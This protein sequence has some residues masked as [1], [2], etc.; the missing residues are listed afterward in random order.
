MMEKVVVRLLVENH[1]MSDLQDKRCLACEGGVKSLSTA[2]KNKLLK[3]INQRW[4]VNE[5]Y[6]ELSSDFK[7]KNY[8]QTMAFINA[9]A[10]MAHQEN[11]HPDLEVGYNH[12][13]VRYSTHAM[14]D[15]TENDFICAAKIDQL[16]KNGE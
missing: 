16:M 4:V 15:L 6:S 11:H 3:Q 7:F 2:E 5:D 13:K 8:Y 9:I 1:I 12:C 14:K 10:W